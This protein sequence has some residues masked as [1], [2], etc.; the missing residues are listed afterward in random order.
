MLWPHLSIEIEQRMSDGVDNLF[1][2][3]EL[4]QVIEVGA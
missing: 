1:P 2:M 3:E 4:G